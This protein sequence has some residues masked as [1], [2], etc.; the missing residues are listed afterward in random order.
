MKTKGVRLYEIVPESEGLYSELGVETIHQS[1]QPLGMRLGGGA[2][3]TGRKLG[4]VWRF[5][6]KGFPKAKAK[7]VKK[8]KKARKQAK[9][10]PNSMESYASG[11]TQPSF[12]AR[13]IRR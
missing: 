7:A 9:R 10:K 4:S 11:M 2:R 13:E 3:Q 6:Q 8:A 1:R 12:F 5:T